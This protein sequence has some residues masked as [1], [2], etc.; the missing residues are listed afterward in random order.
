MKLCYFL[1]KRVHPY[2]VSCL[3]KGVLGLGSFEPTTIVCY[4]PY[5]TVV[6]YILCVCVCYELAFNRGLF[7]KQFLRLL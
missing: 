2:A 7:L 3:S 1:A 6:Y 4:I 5:F